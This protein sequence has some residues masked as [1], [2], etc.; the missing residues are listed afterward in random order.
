MNYGRVMGLLP[1]APLPS[2]HASCFP[3]RPDG[4]GHPLNTT[5]PTLTS[6][7]RRYASLIAFGLF[8]ILAACGGDGIV[9]PNESRPA[10]IV[11]FDGD[12]QSAP[13][14]STLTEPIV[15]KVT[16]GLDRP[17]AGQAVVFAIVSGGGQLSRASAQ[18]GDDG[19]SSAT[20]TVGNSA[21]QQLV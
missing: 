15:V 9:L 5:R 3:G 12:G 7:R 11:I 18:T 16:D 4:G 20:W 17:V 14:G 19:R 13:A 1:V 10:K 6:T 8:T 2:R 21:G